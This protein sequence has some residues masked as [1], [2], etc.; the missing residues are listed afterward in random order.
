MSQALPAP[1]AAANAPRRRLYVA[2][3]LPPQ[4]NG[5]ADYIAEYLPLLARDFDLKL[6]AETAQADA[7][8]AHVAA[9][10]PWPVL[11]EIDFLA[12]QPDARGQLLYNVG[13]N[14]DCAWMLDAAQRFPGVVVVHDISLFYLHQVASARA[15]AP[16]LMARWLAD[17]GHA[18]PDE[19]LRRDGSLARTPGLLYQECLMLRRLVAG[20]TGV[21]VHS[22][23]AEGRLRGA[24]EG[25]PLGRDAGRPLARIPHFVLP[26]P[27]PPTEA[28]RDEVL[29]RF[30]V[31]PDDLLLLAP[32]F[33][34]GNKMLYEIAVA[35]RL[36][37][38]R[39]PRL[40]LV[41]AG[42]ERE[43]EYALSERLAMLWPDP[44]ERPVVTGYLAADELD[45]LLQRADLSFLLRYPT[46]GESSGLLPRAVMGGGEVVTV[47]I[48]AYPEY[49][50][51]AV[52]TVPVGGDLVS[53]LVEAI[54]RAQAGAAGMPPRAQRQA[55]EAARAQALAPAALY[56]RLKALLDDAWSARA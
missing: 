26:P 50:S 43:A 45:V 6:V 14:G 18:V 33:L 42:E 46:Y 52:R 4:R 53:P 15:R 44:T 51:P 7:V 5:L 41:Y 28:R 3:P 55:A 21:M 38:P 17:D 16:A 34:T 22:A 47:D 29:A 8:R 31:D 48:G 19:F 32:G 54:L 13:N 36:A 1:E 25:V 35:A 12:C 24:A 9:L 49:A 23:Y 11:D 30:G 40:K 2:S 39:M 10:G 27:A 56:P 37:A 20:A